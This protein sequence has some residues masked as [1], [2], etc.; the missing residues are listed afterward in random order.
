MR[1]S[2]RS[3]FSSRNSVGLLPMSCG[4]CASEAVTMG[5][6][7]MK[8]NLASASSLCKRCGDLQRVELSARRH[9]AEIGDDAEGR[10]V[11]V[12]RNDQPFEPVHLPDDL[13]ERQIRRAHEQAQTFTLGVALHVHHELPSEVLRPVLLVGQ[14]GIDDLLQLRG[15]SRPSGAGR[16][17]APLRAR[18]SPCRGSPSN[19]GACRT[20]R[21][22]PRFPPSCGLSPR[23]SACRFQLPKRRCWA[24]SPNY[25]RRERVPCEHAGPQRI[26][27]ALPFFLRT[28]RP[29]L[30]V[31]ALRPLGNLESRVTNRTCRSRSAGSGSPH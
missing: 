15:R 14:G 9:H 23:S 29:S 2:S 7:S 1:I 4:K 25:L 11:D 30:L 20:E 28:L 31:T 16:R 24:E 18:R 12:G 3:I 27:I 5:N 19:R 22:L 6:P 21:L 10:A 8:G 17:D 26:C 13:F